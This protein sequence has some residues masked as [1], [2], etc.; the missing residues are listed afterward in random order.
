M[1]QGQ[2][3]EAVALP[4]ARASDGMFRSGR[5]QRE[6]LLTVLRL[7]AGDE[8]GVKAIFERLTNWD[9]DGG[10]GPFNPNIPR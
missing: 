3:T 1:S 2:M 9:N 7:A 5:T 10:P 8:Q 6:T 4:A